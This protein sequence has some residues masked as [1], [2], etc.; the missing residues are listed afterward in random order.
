MCLGGRRLKLSG[1]G[2][3]SPFS[4]LYIIEMAAMQ[5]KANVM[6]YSNDAFHQAARGVGAA[7]KD[8]PVK[9]TEQLVFT[10]IKD[11][12]LRNGGDVSKNFAAGIIHRHF[13]LTPDE[14]TVEEN[15]KAVAMVPTTNQTLYPSNWML[16]D[17]NWYP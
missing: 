11:C 7:W 1:R 2:P 3:F 17:G 6:P 5:E 14:R 9:E 8:F 13:D 12:F 10:V 4:T 16:V 15:G